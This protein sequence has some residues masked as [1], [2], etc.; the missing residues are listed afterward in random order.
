VSARARAVMVDAGLL[1]DLECFVLS[2]TESGRCN[3]C[4]PLPCDPD[5][6]IEDLARRVVEARKAR[7]AKVTP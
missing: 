6:G 7:R 3:S 4:S 1:D 2:M 5:C